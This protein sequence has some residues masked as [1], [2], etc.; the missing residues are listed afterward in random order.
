MAQ[1]ET[2]L[3]RI[4][5]TEA[6]SGGTPL[7]L[8]HGVGSDK[9]VWAPQLAHFGPQR[10]TVALDYL[11]YGES[12]F[13][14]GATREEFAAAMWGTLDALGIGRAHICGLSLGGVV[15]IAMHAAAPERC[16]SLIPADSF[17]VHPDGQA[18][19]D[20][21]LAA[22]AELGMRG[23]AEARVDALL[24]PGAPPGLRDEV[25]ETMATI[26]PAAYALGAKAVWLAD[27]RNRLRPIRCPVLILCGSEDRITPPALSEALKDALPHA[28][29]VE[30]AGAG[31]LSN[32][33]RPAVFNRVI[34]AFLS[35][36]EDENA[37]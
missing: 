33:E 6:G 15:A 3:G 4:G 29:L 19:H 14:E 23:L 31:H 26:D 10:R 12:E 7:V 2:R 25:V 18:I 35:G 32:A 1:V 30:I 5:M 24:A 36:M 37:A 8:L 27:Q 22:A 13:R 17:A 21:S 34:D 16:A 20:R 9:R 28:A 11:G